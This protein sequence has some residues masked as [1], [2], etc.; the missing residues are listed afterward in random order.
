MCAVLETHLVR[1]RH[2]AGVAECWNVTVRETRREGKR[3]VGGAHLRMRHAQSCRLRAKGRTEGAGGERGKRQQ[4]AR[5]FNLS[6]LTPPL[7]AHQHQ[8]RGRGC[9][10][11]IRCAHEACIAQREIAGVVHEDTEGASG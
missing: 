7:N 3:Q 9:R 11:S 6:G 1:S 5:E 4:M 2:W 8:V 10:N